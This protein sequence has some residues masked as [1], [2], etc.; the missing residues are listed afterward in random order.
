MVAFPSMRVICMVA[1]LVGVSHA[2]PAQP[3]RRD[4]DKAEADRLFEEA[5]SLLAA[6]KPDE[7]CD[8]F[9][10]SF[11]K[12]PRAVGTM[13][14]LGLCREELGLLASAIRYYS[15]ARDRARDQHLVE[16]EEA[17]A[18]KIALLSPRVPRIT[19]KLP[20]SAGLKAR[21]LLDDEMIPVELLDELAVDPGSRTFVVTAPGRLAWET[22]L[23]VKEGQRSV[24]HVPPLQGVKTVVVRE[25]TSRRV[26][27]GKVG[28][29]SGS[30]LALAAAGLGLYARFYY[31]QQF[32]PASR[33]GEAAARDG[34]H[35][36][37]TSPGT[38]GGVVRNCSELGSERIATARRLAHVSTAVGIAG[39]A[40]A[41]G[42]LVMWLTAPP[43]GQRTHV[44]VGVSTNTATF[45][46]TRTF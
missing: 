28:V 21:V 20:A 24:V 5:R 40:V 3:S 45:G 1:L 46:V 13:L 29:V 31:W 36:C 23:A 32:P 11:K 22:T 14:N 39:T 30:A 16:H 8:R 10:Q 34:E 35:P 7:A 6:G 12:D 4:E 9:E 19:V 37:W 18:R 41:I 33:D 15:E 2:Q 17:A 42:G 38:T 43:A 25:Q 27:W 26:L 44:E